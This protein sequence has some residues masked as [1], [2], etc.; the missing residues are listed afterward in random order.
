MTLCL[1]ICCSNNCERPCETDFDE[2]DE[3]SNNDDDE[4]MECLS[5][6]T[7]VSK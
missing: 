6:K 3:N 4:E 7:L 2:Y 5:T 1:V